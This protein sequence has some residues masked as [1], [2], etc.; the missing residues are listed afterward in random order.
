MT[1]IIG[2]V[3]MPGNAELF[4]QLDTL[5]LGAWLEGPGASEIVLSWWVYAVCV[6]LILFGVNTL[7][8]FIDWLLH[9]RSRWRKSGEYLLHLGFCL[10]LVA[11][12]WGSFLGTR[13]IRIAIPQGATRPLP[14][15]P[16]YYLKLD[17]FTPRIDDSGRPLDF[18]QQLSLLHGDEIITSQQVRLNHPLV[19]KD[20]VVIPASYRQDASGFLFFDSQLGTHEWLPGKRLRL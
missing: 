1:I 17:S 19:W 4:S 14:A 11:Y 8:C 12:I 6:I 15:M 7:C 2:S 13:D 3:R 10:V 16:G 18:P 20:L 5:V 9:I